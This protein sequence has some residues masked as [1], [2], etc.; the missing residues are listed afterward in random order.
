MGYW[1]IFAKTGNPNTPSAAA[2]PSY[3]AGEADFL[4][5][6]V[7]IQQ[8]ALKLFGQYEFI[9]SFREDGVL[10]LQLEQAAKCIWRLN[11]GLRY[12]CLYPY[13]TASKSVL[14][15]VLDK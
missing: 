12:D 9:V 10:P 4:E 2:W 14:L 11:F 6:G 13:S 5:L 7:A 1:T 8:R 3:G 15:G